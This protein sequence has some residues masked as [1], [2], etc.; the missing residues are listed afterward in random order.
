LQEEGDYGFIEHNVLSNNNRFDLRDD[1]VLRILIDGKLKTRDSLVFS[2][3]HSGVSVTGPLNGM[4]Y[5][6]KPLLVPVKSNTT[7]DT[8]ELRDQALVT[9][10]A[11][12]EYLSLKIPQPPRP[13]PSAIA[14][15]YRLFSPFCAKLIMD[16]R[17]N[18]LQLPAKTTGFTKQE[19]A[20]ICKPY[21]YLLKFDPTQP[22]NVQDDQ[23]VLIDPHVSNVSVGLSA[24]AYQF[25]RQAVDYYCNGKVNIAA[26][27]FV[28]GS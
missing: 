23:F 20:D 2:E 16:L 5:M 28:D 18:T 21:E 27:V 24:V 12:G 19:V 22:E 3:R 6:V 17:T 14:Q 4:P 13:A 8:Y 15:R 1:R 26:A 7:T 25:V 11:I 9:D 10:K